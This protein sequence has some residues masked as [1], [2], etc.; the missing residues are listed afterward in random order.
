MSAVVAVAEH[1]R[2]GGLRV[3]VVEDEIRIGWCFAVGGMGRRW[4]V[5]V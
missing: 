3:E 2:H 4:A 5:S 1:G